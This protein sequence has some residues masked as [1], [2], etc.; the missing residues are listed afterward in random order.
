MM[1]FD[2]YL[3]LAV[4]MALTIVLLS[5]TSPLRKELSE[6]SGGFIPFIFSRFVAGLILGIILPLGLALIANYTE[7]DRKC[8][9]ALRNK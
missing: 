5:A 2:A 4:A 6:A 9:E 3:I 7:Y 1:I 8:L